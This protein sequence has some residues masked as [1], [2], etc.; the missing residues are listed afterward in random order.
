MEKK[1]K[2]RPPKKSNDDIMLAYDK[3]AK[4]GSDLRDVLRDQKPGQKLK[5]SQEDMV[6]ELIDFMFTFNATS[7]EEEELSIVAG[8]AEGFDRDDLTSKDTLTIK[9]Q[10]IAACSMFL[11]FAPRLYLLGDLKK[12]HSDQDPIAKVGDWLE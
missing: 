5:A 11:K 12:C 3:R 9:N 7:S 6:D 4:M 8:P 1:N 2:P 10:Y